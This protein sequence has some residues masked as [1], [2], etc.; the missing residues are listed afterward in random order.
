MI[1]KY[2]GA[3][4]KIA[5][6][7]IRYIPQHEVYLEPFFGSGAVF[8][9]KNKSYLETINDIDLDIF[10]YFNVL[11]KDPKTLAESLKLTCYSRAEYEASYVYDENDDEIEKA[12][13]FAVRCYMGFGASNR[14]KNGFRSSQQGS[15]PKVTKLWDDFP[16][17]LYQA[18][19]R[20]K[21][22]QIE[23]LDALELIKRYDTKDCFIYLD[24]PYVPELRKKYLYKHEYNDEQHESLLKAIVSHP[25]KIMLS[26]Y[27]TEIYKKYLSGW[28]C[29]KLINQT[30]SGKAKTECLY[31][32]YQIEQLN[33]FIL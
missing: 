33:L 9:N 17:K 14:Y 15:S 27:E 11:R 8:F 28:T 29:V 13:K 4:N 32:N 19:C 1:L 5:K 31:M 7:I 6:K 18:S 16:D 23:N 2:P 21:D 12:R 30:E 10:N 3:K 25:G 22:A 20:L 24:P 26:G